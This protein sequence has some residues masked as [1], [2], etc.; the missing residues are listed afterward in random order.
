MQLPSLTFT[1]VA[2]LAKRIRESDGDFLIFAQADDMLLSL[3]AGLLVYDTALRKAMDA[4][5][6]AEADKVTLKASVDEMATVIDQYMTQAGL[7]V[8]RG[9]PDLSE[10]AL[11]RLEADLLERPE[12]LT[13]V[14]WHGQSADYWANV[15]AINHEIAQEAT[16]LTGGIRGHKATRVTIDDAIDV[17]E[18]GSGPIPEIEP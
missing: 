16:K 18:S 4:L 5:M 3:A 10:Q 17:D 7:I 15:G 2:N 1:E 14:W 8:E 9:T 6:E 12:G 11:E 13:G